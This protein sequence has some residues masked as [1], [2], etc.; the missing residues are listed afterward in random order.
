MGTVFFPI[1]PCTKVLVGVCGF[2]NRLCL[3]A[4][5]PEDREV[6]PTVGGTQDRSVGKRTQ[7][8][9]EKGMS[10]LRSRGRYVLKLPSHS[11]C[12]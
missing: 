8:G 3:P 7:W 9:V 10:Q 1:A 2:R 5:V 6:S 11:I 4:L 12:R